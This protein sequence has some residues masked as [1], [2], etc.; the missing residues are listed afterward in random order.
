MPFLTALSQACG[1]EA[2]MHAATHPSQPNYM[3]ATSGIA[4]GV[5]VKVPNDNIFNQVQ[6]LGGT[7]KAYEESMSAACSGL[8]TGLYKS[9]HNPAYFYTDLRTPTNTCT[10][11]DIVMD[12]QLATDIQNDALPTYAWITPNECHDFYWVSEC[13][14]PQPQWIPQ[15]DLWLSNLIPQLTALPSYQAGQTLIVITFDEGATT[16]TAGVDCTD[17]T[18]YVNHPDCHIP[19]VVVSPYIVPGT[20]DT[21]DQN[22]YSLL[23]TTE[24]ILGLA[25]LGNAVGQPSMRPGLGF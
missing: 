16:G 4:S 8:Y 10:T 3:A 6:G 20:V 5:G 2:D 19:T 23:G 15:G 18:Y 7:W 21:S 13:S 22:L 12:P 25:R 9:G 1:S 11:N 17:P 24:D 14:T